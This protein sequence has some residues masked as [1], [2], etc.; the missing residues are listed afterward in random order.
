[1]TAFFFVAPLTLLFTFFLQL[2][3]ATKMSHVV[4]LG[5]HSHG[6]EPSSTDMDFATNSHHDLL[7]SVMGSHEKAR[8]ALIYS[9][10]KHINGFA[11][12]LEEKEAQE[13]KKK[14]NVVSVFSTKVHK[15]HTTRSYEFLGLEKNIRVRGQSAW[16]KAR[17]GQN[18][19]IANIDTG[20]WPES[21]SFNDKGYGPVPAKWR[22]NGTCE[23]DRL[24][25][26]KRSPCNR[27]L[28]GARVFYKGY[29]AH[30]GT[31]IKSPHSARDIVGH[32]THTLSTAAGNFVRGASVL[33]NGDG[34]AKG[35]SP[36]ARVVAYKACWSPTDASGCNEADLLAAFDQAINDGVEVLF[37]SAGGQRHFAE[38]LLTDGISI[39][40]YHATAKGIVV[41]SSAGNEGPD[42][43]TV[44]NVA[45]W[46]FTVAASTI[47]R[48]FNDNVTL[49]N[50]QSI[51]ATGL[52][53]GL[54]SDKFYPLIRGR[55]AKLPNVTAQEADLCNAGTLD[56]NK[57]RGK[58][59]ICQ[60]GRSL[61]PVDKG[62]NA[63]LAGAVAMILENDGKS[64][65]TVTADPQVLPVS[66]NTNKSAGTEG[67]EY[68]D[69]TKNPVASMGKAKTFLGIR[70]APIMASFSSRGP[71][72]I[73]PSL[74]K[75]DI[76]APG[77]NILASYSL[78]ASP[79]NLASDKRRFTF[80]IL[81]GT[82]MACPHVAG[83]VGLLKTR[84]P[85]WSPAAIKS[86]I[87]TTAT[88]FDNTNNLIRDGVNEKPA[89]PFAYGSGHVRPDL[90][91]NPGLVY[92][93][94][95][96][97]YLN[98]LCGSGYSDSLVASFNFNKI[99]KC[100]RS[101]KIEDFNYPSISVSVLEAKP[102]TVTRT[103]TN[104]GR[105]STYKATVQ[106]P[107]GV[108]V[109]VQPETLS[110]K[111]TGEK[112]R[113]KVTFQTSRLFQNASFPFGELLWT[114]GKHRVRSPI[115]VLRSEE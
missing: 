15:L 84:H 78:A 99:Y 89:T 47:D 13:L 30:E 82:S 20:V 58:I 41:I 60:R 86:A 80:N 16:I 35:G 79:S 85:D 68:Y 24:P 103:V 46:V 52:S 26:S 22:G 28:I 83:I 72:A 51:K 109:V 44:K 75:P 3:H 11:A 77:L 23:I 57:V 64:G 112:K 114:D 1:M 69:I 5:S 100:P 97:D 106:A 27:K 88:T 10:N 39:G 14:P 105:A 4:Y 7:A 49:G 90:A 38:D 55:D 94:S 108:K 95:E 115:V 21:K 2:T 43:G 63:L 96:S 110:F 56:P 48:D 31:V 29:E 91:L 101:Y 37:V 9:Y 76:T 87:M 17:F 6:P 111:K 61:R 74:L 67:T 93:L 18:T 102:V 107:K 62:Q 33:N 66:G 12:S 59:L 50:N 70:P 32:G 65:D 81:S 8:E 36:R 40:A 104:V 19:I 73:Q 25:G 45:P 53:S 113:F 98:F 71:N 54:P 34:T 92:D 42:P